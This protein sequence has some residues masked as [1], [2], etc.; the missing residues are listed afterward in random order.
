MARAGPLAAFG[1]GIGSKMP[2]RGA[3]A[4]GKLLLAVAAGVIS[5]SAVLGD[6]IPFSSV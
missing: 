1:V 2:D 5:R 6:S 3:V 4:I